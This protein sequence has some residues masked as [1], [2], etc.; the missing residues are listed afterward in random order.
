M[1]NIL[2]Q[3][4]IDLR[5]GSTSKAYEN[6]SYVNAI[7]M[8]L[9]EKP[10]LNTE[11]VE[12]LK[13]IITIGNI[14]Y[15]DTDKELMVIE[16]GFY[17]LLL[18]KYKK[19]D[20][21]FQ[22]GAEVID[23]KTSTRIIPASNLDKP[24]VEGVTFVD[25]PE[26]NVF[27]EDILIDPT[28]YMDARDFQHVPQFIDAQYI[29][30][31]THT[32]QSEHPEL[33]GTLDKA[34][35]V[36]DKDAE[37]AGVLNNPNVSTVERDF[38][39]NHIM[40][41]IIDPTKPFDIVLELKYDGI[42]VEADCT[43]EVV[44][45]RSRGD[46]GVG[47][48]SD[49]TPILK[50]YKFPHREP[51]CE[52]IGVKFEAIITKTDLPF[53][54]KAKGYEYKNCRSAIVGLFGSSDAWK[55]RDF[56]TLIPLAVEQR[57]YETVCECDR[58]KE[59]EFLNRYFISK[60]QP[61][62]Y[63]YGSGT[64]IE[65]L[66]WTNL[67][68]QEVE[69]M[70]SLVPFMYDGVVL[71]YRDEKIRKALGRENYINKFSIAVK[72]NPLKRFTTYRGFEVTVGKDGTI[73]PMLYFDPVEFYGT[74]HNKSSGHSLARFNQLALHKGDMITVEYVNDVMPYVTKPINDFNMANEK[75][76]PLEVFPT[77]C[78]ICGSPIV[79]S[80]SGKSAKCINPDCKGR[81]IGRM[82]DMCAKLGLVG[83]GEAT[84]SQ[85][86]YT[87]LHQMIWELSYNAINNGPKILADKGFGPVEADNIISQVKALKT[88]PVYDTV[89]LGAL[90][91]D[92]VSTKTFETIASVMNLEKLYEMY[93]LEVPGLMTDALAKIPGIGPVTAKTIEDEFPTFADDIFT[94]FT[95]CNVITWTPPSGKKVVLSGTR[96][97]ELVDFLNTHGFVCDP[98][99]SLTK[100]TDILVIPL[101]GYTSS[102]VTKA[103]SYGIPI[104]TVNDIM[105]NY[106]A[107]Q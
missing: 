60:G 106:V 93:E 103:Q 52:S 92:N 58:V 62:R 76:S 70:R 61:L 14:V 48:V 4:L 30:K 54:N 2:K 6:Q 65:N 37:R 40:R 86:G 22:V 95:E 1:N 68:V 67:F 3:I 105:T 77:V 85:M 8:H 11:D 18:E 26:D 28:K 5:N 33:I 104:V 80:D 71:S 75:V 84:I 42:S 78:P 79:I 88:N 102:K 39:A 45:A 98:N 41:G 74:I 100:S 91:F 96:D 81:A 56:I 97:Q 66:A 57:I 63:T 9:Y 34:K 64:Y 23:F 47:K 89:F 94:I 7:A 19:Y 50:G 13:D 29:S 36:I 20:P 107:Y 90:G 46:T 51:G 12:D 27:G 31:R 59:I 101:D 21:N 17:D 53:F 72:F 69:S 25:I 43:D 49:L 16:D 44:S 83:F 24:I 73:T 82:V 35:F 38:F 32:V 15:N 55:Y 99:A 10:Q 87:H